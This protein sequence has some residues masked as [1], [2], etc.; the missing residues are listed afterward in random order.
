MRCKL[1]IIYYSQ[2]GDVARLAEA[3]TSQLKPPAA[4]Q[5]WAPIEPAADYPYPWTL[6]RFLDVFPECVNGEPPEIRP[7]RFNPDAQYDLVILCYQVWYLSPSLPIQAFM[8]SSYARVLNNK[9]VITLV[10]CR[11]MW[12]SASEKMKR[13]ISDAGG[14]HL[15]NIVIQHQGSP[16]ATLITTPRL[17]L[18]GKKDRF[19]GIMPPAGFHDRDLA[20]LSRFGARLARQLEALAG[21]SAEPLLS[22]LGAVA[23]N[24]RLVIAERIGL[25]A[26]RPWAR[27][28]RR[29]GKPGER[30]R[31]P[32]IV[33]FAVLLVLA[34]PFV[35]LFSALAGP[36]L[37]RFFPD[38]IDAYIDRLKS[39]SDAASKT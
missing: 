36:F 1:L 8:R 12:H 27:L 25:A 9:K 28:A 34:I 13:L 39:P 32:V 6:Y 18:T 38:K 19:L 10:G 23:I 26:Y 4:D 17:L 33:C 7:P 2:S 3:L 16:M 29:V 37:R 5:V 30:R 35:L 24:E 14:I 20:S 31:L 11:G 15:D 21:P 22:G